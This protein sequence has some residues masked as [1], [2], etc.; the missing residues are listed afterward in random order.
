M[1][2]TLHKNDIPADLDLGSIVAVDTEAMGLN[3]L[4]DRLCVAQLSSGD[5]TAHLVQFEPD[6]FA[7]PN[8]KKLLADPDVVKIF[9]FARFDVA[10]LYHYLG[11]ECTPLYC[12]KTASKLCRTYTDRHGLRELCRVLLDTDLS[13]VQQTT[14]WGAESLTEDQLEY[15]ASDVLH[16]H[17]LK[18][19]LD[20]LLSRENRYDLARETMDCIMARAKLDLAGWQDVDIFAH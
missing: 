15:A 1:T 6:T 14:D 11:I 20:R 16:L 5:G 17:K 18:D 8:L 12:T 13:K 7:A 4:R 9:H 2:I 3:N 10:I 19:K